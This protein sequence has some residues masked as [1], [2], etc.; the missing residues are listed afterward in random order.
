MQLAATFFV[1]IPVLFLLDSF[2]LKLYAVWLAFF[3]WMLFRALS[4]WWRFDKMRELD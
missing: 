2:G 1:F 4:L 3:F